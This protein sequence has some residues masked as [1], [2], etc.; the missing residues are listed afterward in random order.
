M[1]SPKI[2]PVVAFRE[3]SGPAAAVFRRYADQFTSSAKTTFSQLGSQLNKV[4]GYEEIE[5]LK[6]RVVEQ[7]IY[8]YLTLITW[9]LM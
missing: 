4:T 7:G 1:N 3:W 2:L 6:R 9:P 8:V 5:A